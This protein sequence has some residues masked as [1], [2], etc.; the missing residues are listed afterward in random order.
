LFGIEDP[1][2]KGRIAVVKGLD[3]FPPDNIPLLYYSYHIMV[4]LGTIFILVMTAALVL[5]WRRKLFNARW[6][7]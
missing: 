4:G 6:M 3:E 7:L 1:S 2:L 5:L